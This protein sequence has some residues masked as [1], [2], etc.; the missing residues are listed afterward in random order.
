[1]YRYITVT[2]LLSMIWSTAALGAGVSKDTTELIR[3]L[4][5]KAVVMAKGK[6]AE[7]AKD[8]LDAAQSTI[9]AAQAAISAGNEKDAQQ[10]AGLAELQLQVAETKGA[11]KDLSEQVAVRRSELKKQE[12]LLERYRQGEEN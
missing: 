2:V 9:T 7:Y 11:E 4:G 10:K 1:M 3:Q 5:E 6:T 12:A 8:L